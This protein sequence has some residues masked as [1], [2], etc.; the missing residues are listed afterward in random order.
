MGSTTKDK[1]RFVKE[2]PKHKVTLTTPFLAWKS[3]VTQQQYKTLMKT[4]PSRFQKC[5]GKCPVERVSWHD[6][7]RFANALSK[8]QKKPACFVCKSGKCSLAPAYQKG[9]YHK[10]KGWRLPTEAEWEYM[11]WAGSSNAGKDKFAGVAMNKRN[12]N[13]STVPVQNSGSNSWGLLGMKSNVF[14]WTLDYKY[15]KYSTQTVTNPLQSAPAA[16]RVMRGG[17]WFLVMWKTRI[18]CREWM[19]PSTRSHLVGF[20]PVRSL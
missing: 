11:A 7:A 8:L 3:E 5:G 12:I 20:R 15:R 9:N 2:N 4:N 18:S 17:C 19:L 10:C 13:A 14:E 1:F 6:A 16:M